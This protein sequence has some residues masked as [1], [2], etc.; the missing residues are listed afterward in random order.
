M[1]NCKIGK[2]VDEDKE[3]IS[4]SVDVVRSKNAPHDL[5]L[6]D[7]D[8]KFLEMGLCSAC[9]DNVAEFYVK[10]PNSPCA[11]LA[12]RALE[13]DAI[14]IDKLKNAPHYCTWKY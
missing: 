11:K 2:R 7:L 10:K 1:T 3:E 14:A 12:K 5:R 8:N 4:Y 9:A 13:G 6:D